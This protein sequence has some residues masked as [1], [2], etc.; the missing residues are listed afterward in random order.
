MKIIYK[1]IKNIV[2]RLKTL[3][4]FLREEKDVRYKSNMIKNIIFYF[5]GFTSDKFIAY[6]LDKNDYKDY[7]S[8]YRRITTVL[9]NGKYNFILNNKLIFEKVFSSSFNIPKNYALINNGSIVKLFENSPIYDSNSLYSAIKKYRNIVIKPVQGGG[10]KNVLIIKNENDKLSINN[11]KIDLETFNKRISQLNNCV[12]TEYVNQSKFSAS[13]YAKSTNTIRMLL[14][15]DI[16]SGKMK[17]LAAAQRIGSSKSKGMDNISSGG[18][19]AQIDTSNGE[20]LKSISIQKEGNDIKKIKDYHPD[21]KFKLVG[22]QIP[23]WEKIKLDICS[24][25]DLFP[26]INY[27]GMDIVITDD[28]YKIIEGN[29]YSNP[30]VHQLHEPL[31]KYEEFNDFLKYHNIC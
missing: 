2:F 6:E 16:D 4:K 3:R 9:L 14:Y 26:Y 1:G 24:K 19:S 18:V 23:N 20:I 8:D 30:R 13:L 21:T 10:G 17:V 5:R 15:R 28:G 29:S 11:E 7:L 25:M 12:I 22:L 31:L 27:I